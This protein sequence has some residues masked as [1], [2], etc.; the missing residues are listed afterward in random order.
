MGD[1]MEA[2]AMSAKDL[3]DRYIDKNPLTVMTRCSFLGD[4][5]GELR[6]ASQT[7]HASRRID[8]P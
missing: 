3:I 2:I 1:Y 7:I 5:A 4:R 8:L 6:N